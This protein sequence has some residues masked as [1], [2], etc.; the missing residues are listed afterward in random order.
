[1][2]PSGLDWLTVKPGK[3]MKNPCN[4]D[5]QSSAT[6]YRSDGTAVFQACQSYSLAKQ[7]EKNVL[8]ILKNY[9]FNTK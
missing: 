6:D 7:T 3:L 4:I 5:L 9:S 1:M 2:E 8:M